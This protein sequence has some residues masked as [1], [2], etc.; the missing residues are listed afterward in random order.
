MRFVLASS[1]LVVGCGGDARSDRIAKQEA[2][3]KAKVVAIRKDRPALVDRAVD[4][5]RKSATNNFGEKEAEA[6]VI[7][8]DVSGIKDHDDDRWVVSG[9][10]E[11]RD[12]VG[13]RFT[14][15]FSVSLQVLFYSLHV[16]DVQMNDPEYNEPSNSPPKKQK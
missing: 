4:E 13:R 11:G 15:P 7:T 8:A 9:K 3:A 16:T 14:A 2:A 6:A 5:V 1:L 10:Y 12:K